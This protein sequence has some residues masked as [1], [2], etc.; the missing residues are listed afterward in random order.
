MAEEEEKQHQ[1]QWN[2]SNWNATFEDI[3]EAANTSNDYNLLNYYEDG[4]S[5]KKPIILSSDEEDQQQQQQPPLQSSSPKAI[6]I[7]ADPDE[8][9][10]PSQTEEKEEEKESELIVDTKGDDNTE[11]H[12]DCP[13]LLPSK[14]ATKSE[15]VTDNKSGAA[16]T[17]I[18][19]DAGNVSS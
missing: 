7:S 17:Q 15:L 13:P 1:N 9:D 6:V 16:Q 14:P 8:P 12:P 18:A 11:A 10:Q 2:T 3:D 19:H 5:T 4:H